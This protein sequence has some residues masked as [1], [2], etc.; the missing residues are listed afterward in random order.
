[1]RP[2]R[3]IFLLVAL[4]V[5]LPARADDRRD[6]VLAARQAALDELVR[7]VLTMP[8]ETRVT[9]GDVAESAQADLEKLMTHA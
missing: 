4:L 1:M 9:V 8:I 7:T 5:A 3:P 2:T 6:L